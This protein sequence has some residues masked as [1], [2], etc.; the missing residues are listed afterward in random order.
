MNLMKNCLEHSPEG[1]AVCCD[2]EDNPL[3]VRIRIWDEGK[4]FSG[5][6]L[7]H[8]FER[9]YRGEETGRDGIG[10]GLYLA[11]EI[12]EAQNGALEAY[13]RPGGGACFE[14]RLYHR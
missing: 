6:D 13:N 12:L 11:K 2:W 10:I 3:Y 4:G 14:I 1:G 7:P 8:L 5:K 9:F